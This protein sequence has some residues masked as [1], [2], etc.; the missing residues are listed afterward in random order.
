MFFSSQRGMTGM[1][2]GSITIY[3]SYIKEERVRKLPS[4]GERLLMLKEFQS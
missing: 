3:F 2:S 4:A 1:A